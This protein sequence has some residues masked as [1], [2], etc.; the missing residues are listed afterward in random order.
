M[1]RKSIKCLS[2]IYSKYNKKFGLRWIL[3]KFNICSNAYYNYF[4]KR[5]ANYYYRNKVKI[6]KT[7]RELYHAYNW[8]PRYRIT[9]IYLCRKGY[10]ISHLT[11]HKY[12]NSELQLYSITRRINSSYER[13]IAHKAYNNKFNSLEINRKWC[14][15][16]TYLY[17]TNGSNLYNCTIIDLYDW[18][19]VAGISD[20]N[21][22]S[23]LAKRILQKAIDSQ[24]GI[25]LHKL[26]LCSDQGSQ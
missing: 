13:G 25:E 21:I 18:S 20:R 6:K 23:D 8:A 15:D 26:M 3:K 12:M 10:D 11:T 16:F 17:L 5:K 22:T 9:H 14:T 19:V 4:K 1:R 7:T 24:L 2:I